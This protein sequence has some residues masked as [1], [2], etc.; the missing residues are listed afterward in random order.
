MNHFEARLSV[1]IADLRRQ[2]RIIW[3]LILRELAT[4]Y[5]RDNIGFLWLVGEPLMFCIGVTI[6][7]SIIRAPFEHGIGVV[8]FTV[9]GYLPLTLLRHL[10]GQSVNCLRANSNLLYHKQITALKLFTA[11]A[12][13]EIAGVSA[14]FFVVTTLMCLF[15]LMDPP[16]NIALVITGWFLLAWIVFGLGLIFGCL[17]QY[18]D[19]V[20]RA[21]QLLTYVMLPMTGTF[22]MIAW[23]PY[24][25]RETVDKIPF[26][27]CSEMIRKG[28]FGEF[29]PAYFHVTYTVYWALGL[30]FIGLILCQMI[31]DRV[32][33]E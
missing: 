21:M 9:T 26:I 28:F 15:G 25:Y 13:L 7:W 20:E 5:G 10:L 27:N 8:A 31:R 6:M 16:K 1:L 19:I 24:Q 2:R 12:I 4:R 14:T 17:S 30:T 23:L 32:E 3:A 33:L 22:Y 11:R 18:S 29:V